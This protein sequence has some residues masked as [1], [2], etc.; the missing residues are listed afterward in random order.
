MDTVSKLMRIPNIVGIKDSSADMKRI[1]HLCQ[2]HAQR[3][4]FLIYTGTDDCLLPALA[5]GVDGSMTAFAAAVPDWVTDVHQ[6]FAQGNLPQATACQR[7]MM[8]LLAVADALPFPLGYKMVAQT[9]HQLLM[10][11]RVHQAVPE[12]AAQAAKRKIET[13]M[14]GEAATA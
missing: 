4:D 3:E 5:A 14:R 12:D 9:Y 7:R 8:P 10:T 6:A 1:S 2:L 11:Q 13:L